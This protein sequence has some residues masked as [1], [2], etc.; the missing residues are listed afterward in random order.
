V[1]PTIGEGIG[2]GDGVGVGDGDGLGVGAAP[3]VGG[4][5]DPSPPQPPKTSA[6]ANAI[7]LAE[8]LNF[9]VPAMSLPSSEGGMSASGSQEAS[10]FSLSEADL[11]PIRHWRGA[12]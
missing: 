1:D 8:R 12:Q 7:A 11:L 9:V 2:D 6:S 10:L 4:A 3:P 5:L